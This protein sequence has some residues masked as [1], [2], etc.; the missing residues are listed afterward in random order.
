[1]W[2][3]DDRTMWK[4]FTNDVSFESK[5]K[6]ELAKHN[7]YPRLYA[8]AEHG[9]LVDKIAPEIV[10][11][12][13]L[14]PLR[15]H[16]ICPNELGLEFTCAFKD[17]QETLGSD[18]MFTW[19]DSGDSSKSVYFSDDGFLRI[20]IDGVVSVY[21]TDI[22]KCDMS[23]RFAVFLWAYARISRV[24]GVQFAQRIVK[25]CAQDTKLYNPENRREF[26]VLQPETFFEYSGH[27][28]TT[29]LNNVASRLIF[30]SIYLAVIDH[31]VVSVETIV[32]AAA[33]VGYIVTVKECSSLASSTFLKRAYDGARSFLCLG[34]LLRSFGTIEAFSPEVFGLTPAQY[35]TY[36]KRELFERYGY[37]RLTGLVNEPGNVILSALRAR[38][39]VPE[40]VPHVT[41]VAA[42]IERYGIHSYDLEVLAG[43]IHQMSYGD[44][45][46]CPALDAI[47]R[48]DYS[49]E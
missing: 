36:T 14:T 29:V 31:G 23:N 28:M 13:D 38:F 32:N 15:F 41:P 8:S 7:S 34:T 42:L 1:M 16:E 21:E 3:A 20:V 12:A 44:S 49:V 43:L 6:D 10:K 11:V 30:Y 47:F 2:A 45:L 9:C 22:S 27:V 46:S 33:A 19:F 18:D 17:C 40:R 37:M 5:L 26:V 4:I 39:G 24:A 35:N 25:Q 48:V